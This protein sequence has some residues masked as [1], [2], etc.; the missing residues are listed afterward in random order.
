MFKLFSRI[1]LLISFVNALSPP[2]CNKGKCSSDEVCIG[3]GSGSLGDCYKIN[4]AGQCNQDSDC[5]TDEY[6][7]EQTG[8][9]K[10]LSYDFSCTL[11]Y[12][13]GDRIKKP[14]EF[15][16]GLMHYDDNSVNN[17]GKC[18][19]SCQNDKHCVAYGLNRN[20]KC[21]IWHHPGSGA[22]LLY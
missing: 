1:V 7:I 19:K 6:C 21:E 22:M 15:L 2:P 20:K 11:I 17:S 16:P 14:S 13:S 5:K 8:K 4:K 9:C 10:Q 18:R 3:S 12:H